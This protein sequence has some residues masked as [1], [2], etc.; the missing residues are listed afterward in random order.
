MSDNKNFE[1]LINK[2]KYQVFIMYCPA[3]FPFNF[4]RH[5]WIVINKKGEI[6]RYEIRHALNKINNSH[7]FVNNQFPF[8]GIQKTLFVDKKWEAS[9]LEYVE[10]DFAEK[11]IRVIENT[12]LVYPY[13]NKYFGI[14]PNSNTYLR[15]ILNQFPELKIPLSWRFIGKDFNV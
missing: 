14:G 3:Y 11:I 2:D 15:W 1:N 12:F 7:F 10:G 4:F 8:E 5:P 6:S 9:L 13:C